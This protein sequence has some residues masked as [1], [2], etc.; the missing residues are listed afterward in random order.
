M[1]KHDAAIVYAEQPFIMIIFTD[2][3]SYDDI[4]KIADDV[5]QVLK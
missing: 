1:T 5:Y 3:S 2:K 4:T